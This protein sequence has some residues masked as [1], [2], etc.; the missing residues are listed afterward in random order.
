MTAELAPRPGRP[1]RRRR[2][3]RHPVR[4]MGASSG[5]ADGELLGTMLQRHPGDLPGALRAWEARMRPFIHTEQDSAFIMRRIF[6]PHDRREQIMRT[7]ML[8]L[9]NRPG[10][11]QAM[12][13]I[14]NCH[15]LTLVVCSRGPVWVKGGR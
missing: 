7:V 2:L 3:V 1:G 4:G 11:G 13:K 12:G 14:I 10:L 5:I 8:R 6:T 15:W 9:M